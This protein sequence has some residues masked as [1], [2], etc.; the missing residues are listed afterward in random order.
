MRECSNAEAGGLH[1]ASG[2][3]GVSRWGGLVG[4]NEAGDELL[5]GYTT[6]SSPWLHDDLLSMV[7][8]RAGQCTSRADNE[9]IFGYTTT[10]SP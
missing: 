7:A 3:Q 6:T 4:A 9:L 2:E 1:R 10:S 8:R 5:L